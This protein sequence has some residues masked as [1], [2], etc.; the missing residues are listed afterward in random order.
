[1]DVDLVTNALHNLLRNA[2]QAMPSGGRLWVE[3][4][5][6]SSGD[7]RYVVL[8]VADSGTGMDARTAERAFEEGFTTRRDGSGLGLAF[9]RRVAIAHG[10]RVVLR[11][12]EGKGT[13]VEMWLPRADQAGSPG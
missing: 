12:R 10:G 1:M 11:S 9:V 2:A 4:R 5:E 7:T 3:T 8:A 6:E 13:R